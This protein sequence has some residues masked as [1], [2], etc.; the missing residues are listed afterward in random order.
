MDISEFDYSLD[1]KLIAQQPLSRREASK[2]MILNRD[3]GRITHSFFY[4]FLSFVSQEYIL[5]LNNTKVFPARL[6]AHTA[7]GKEI[8]VLL[9]KELT[10][11]VWE[12]MAKPLKKIK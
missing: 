7:E 6:Y 3:T 5:V 4:D 9:V 12:T 10:D 8:E 2:M 11:G 1:K